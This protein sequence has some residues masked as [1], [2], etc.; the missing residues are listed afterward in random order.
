MKISIELE[1][2]E[3]TWNN[4]KELGPEKKQRLIIQVSEMLKTAVNNERIAKLKKLLKELQDES[5]GTNFDAE[6]LY[7]ILRTEDE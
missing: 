1:V 3:V 7:E 5:G 4:Y 6:I 2:D